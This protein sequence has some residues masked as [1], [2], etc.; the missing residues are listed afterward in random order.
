MPLPTRPQAQLTASSALSSP[1]RRFSISSA[2]PLLVRSGYPPLS[3]P[4]RHS[5][6]SSISS[7]FVS[8]VSSSKRY[9]GSTFGFR[10]C[11]LRTFVV[12]PV[13]PLAAGAGGGDEGRRGCDEA[14]GGARVPVAL[15]DRPVSGATPSRATEPDREP[16]GGPALVLPLRDCGAP[17]GAGPRGS[18]S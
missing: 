18:W 15:F 14:V 1:T 17:G 7:T 11:G 2:L 9:S 6:P 3:A 8:T 5:K 10:G 13:F 16:V 12:D 4:P